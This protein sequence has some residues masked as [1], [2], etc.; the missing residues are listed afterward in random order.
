[1]RW[2]HEE[3]RS[4]EERVGAL[5]AWRAEF[6]TDRN[7]Y[8]GILDRDEDRV[9]GACGLHQRVGDGGT[10][11]GYWIRENAVGRGFAPEAA[12]ALTRAAFNICRLARVEIH[13]PVGNISSERV[14]QKLG[15]T[16][17]A[18]LKSRLPEASPTRAGLYM[19]ENIY[20]MFAGDFH[21]SRAATDWNQVEMRNSAGQ[22]LDMESGDVLAPSNDPD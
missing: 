7:F 4:F 11:I 14:P 3:P 21:G 12:A 2:A 6:D 10:E 19:D 1:M 15:F 22:E 8:Y 18:T 16:Y 17:E 5:R 9:L 20:S 13:V